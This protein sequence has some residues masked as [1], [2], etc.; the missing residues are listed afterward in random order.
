MRIPALILILSLCSAPVFCQESE[1]TV[2]Y[3]AE[4][5]G[6][7]AT[8]DNTPFWMLYH[9]WGVVPR[10]ANNFYLRAAVFDEHKINKDWSYKL[11]LDVVG[12]TP[13]NF[14]TVWLQQ[15]YGELNWKS[16]R[17]NIGAKEDYI[18]PLDEHLSSGDMSMSNHARPIPE[19]KISLSDYVL[20]PYTKGNMFFKGDFSIG[21]T[22][23][24]QWL[25]DTARPNNLKYARDVLTH[26]KSVYFRFGD[27][28]NRHRMQFTVALKHFSQW[29]G[30][31]YKYLIIDG[32]P[33]YVLIDQPQQLKN[34]IRVIFA[35]Q[36]IEG[37]SEADTDNVAGSHSGNYYLQFDYKLNNNDR[38]GIYYQH[39]FEDGSSMNPR[40]FMDMLLGIQYK[41][42]KQQLVSNVLFEYLYTRN[43]AGSVH[44]VT[45]DD[46]HADLRKKETG[47]D[48]YY[49]NTDYNQGPS[50]YGRS[51]GTALLLSPEYNNDGSVNFRSSRIRAFHLGMEGYFLP[52][53]QYRLLL[54]AGQSWGRYYVPFTKVKK[55]FA[56]SL[57]LL[58]TPAKIKDFEAKLAIGYDNG[59]FF[60]GDTF[61]GGITL[62]KRGIIFSK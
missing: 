51:M 13:H 25:E 22:M 50:H 26:H 59:Q 56:S 27:I 29:G 14:S 30:K 38:L 16:L 54:T 2:S 62:S 5:F 58:Y 1:M 10:N 31:L 35:Q 43:Q 3:K 53:L 55:G 18:S 49:N 20:V 37:S 46:E 8:G 4:T 21:R 19:V 61:G 36:G 40:T 42:G 52:E 7:L 60:G 41:T 23:D 45:M 6:S 17:L 48:D 11:G 12:S 15:F 44:F 9:N 28:E 33:Q 32:T 39:F 24:G 34:F 57:E 47:N